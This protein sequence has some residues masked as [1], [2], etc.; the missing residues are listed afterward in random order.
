MIEHTFIADRRHV[1]IPLALTVFVIVGGL[2]FA[3][4]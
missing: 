4:G 1:A 2:I 3:F